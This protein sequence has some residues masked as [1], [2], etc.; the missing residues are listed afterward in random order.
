[1]FVDG[2]QDVVAG[3]GCGEVVGPGDEDDAE[4]GVEGGGVGGADLRIRYA[5]VVEAAEVFAVGAVGF[6]EHFDEGCDVEGLDV[7]GARCVGQLEEH[8]GGGVLVF[9]TKERD[10]GDAFGEEELG[11]AFC[12]VEHGLGRVHAAV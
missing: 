6:A 1:M 11:E 12:G 8:V 3:F 7:C 4:E 10:G 9:K 2:G 5:G